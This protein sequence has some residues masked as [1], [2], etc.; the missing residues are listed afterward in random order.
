MDAQGDFRVITLENVYNDVIGLKPTLRK[1]YLFPRNISTDQE[2]ILVFLGRWLSRLSRPLVIVNPLAGDGS[3]TR[4]G[5]ALRLHVG[6]RGLS[7]PAG[8]TTVAV[9][10]RRR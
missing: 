5:R 8:V 9:S 6:R 1:Q 4:S 3:C 10:I 7:T 2:I